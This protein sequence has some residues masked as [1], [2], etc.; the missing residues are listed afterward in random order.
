MLVFAVAAFQGRA[1]RQSGCLLILL[2]WLLAC[3][4]GG[5]FVEP[6][7]P[8]AELR[9]L[10][11]SETHLPCKFQT[12]SDEQVVQVIW[13]REKPDGT[14]EQIITAHHTEGQ[15][16]FPGFT[17]RV[18]F[19]HSS[20]ILNSAL[21]I[22]HTEVSDESTYICQITTFPSGISETRLSLTVWTKPIATLDPVVLVEGQVFRP[23]ATCRSMARPPARLSWDSDVPGVPQNRSMDGGITFSQFSLHPV[24]GMNGRK[25]DCLVWHPSQKSP[26]RLTNQLVVHFPPDATISGFDRNWYVGLEGAELK[27]DGGGNPKP[28]NFTWTRKGNG[29]PEGVSIRNNLLRF[30]RPLSLTDMGVYRCV[31]V[32]PVGSG[33]AEINITIAESPERQTSFDSLLIIIIGAAAGAVVLIL[34]IIVIA[35]NRYHKRK[36]KQLAIELNVKNEEISTLSRQASI[37]RVN[38]S[39]TEH[40]YQDDL[41]VE[42]TL[43]TSL[44]SLARPRSRDSRSTVGAGSVDFLGRPSI[45]NTSRRGRER[46]ID[47]DGETSRMMMESYNDGDFIPPLHPSPSPFE[48]TAEIRA[49]NGNGV[50]LSD[51]RPRSGGTSR[52]QQSPINNYP[53]LTDEE[54]EENRMEPAQDEREREELGMPRGFEEPDGGEHLDSE[55][56][57][58]QYE[59]MVGF[60]QRNGTLPSNLRN[61]T[62]HSPPPLTI[63]PKAQ[64]V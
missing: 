58:S 3:V 34:V 44:S 31:T 9:S 10:A 30:N 48:Q 36:N 62:F 64:I 8:S 26:A 5:E 41:K 6:S 7:S 39:S 12:D 18:R 33:S 52:G 22:L 57:L 16:E 50:L 60:G 4:M 32:N 21:V 27:C 24:R 55:A 28:H 2:L 19:E 40:R 14:K 1:V 25:L 63:I 17:G 29:L 11:E 54:E 47:R 35:M 43:R 37:R 45:Y 59:C 51:G 23:A 13:S 42:G 61:S 20:P 15:T 53:P 38:T 49:L 46:M 56:A